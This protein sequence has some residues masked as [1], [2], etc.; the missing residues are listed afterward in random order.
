M[1]REALRAQHMAHEERRRLLALL[2]RRLA[3]RPDIIF[4]VAFGGFLED[5]PFRDLDIGVYLSRVARAAEDVIEASLYAEDLA[6]ELS[7]VAD[8]PVDVVVLNHAPPWLLYRALRGKV[9][10]DKDPILRARLYLMAMDNLA[11]VRWHG[12]T[13]RR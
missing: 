4:A 1:R 11:L 12:R 5:R 13:A 3:S 6:S 9:L 10:V 7:G 2:A 8:L